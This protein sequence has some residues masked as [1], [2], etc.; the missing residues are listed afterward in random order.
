[1][2]RITED[3]A[4]IRHVLAYVVELYRELTTENG[5]PTLG[6]QNQGVDFIL[7]DRS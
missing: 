1:M 7:T 2:T 3:T 4:L 6:T 5:A